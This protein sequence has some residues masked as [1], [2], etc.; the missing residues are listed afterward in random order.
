MESVHVRYAIYTSLRH[1]K[2]EG[3]HWELEPVEAFA[4]LR[5]PKR[6]R[7]GYGIE[8]VSVF[9]LPVLCPA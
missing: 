4:C 9:G 3:G 1:A 5:G 2:M 6:K 7:F 8:R